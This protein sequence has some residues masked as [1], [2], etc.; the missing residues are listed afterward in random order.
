M[1]LSTKDIPVCLC[2]MI[3]VSIE[4]SFTFMRRHP[5]ISGVLILLIIVYLF[6]SYIYHFLVYLSPFLVCAA[7]FV[8]I[9]WSSEQDPLKYIKGD[10]KKA[11]QRKFDRQYTEIPSHVKRDLALQRRYSLRNATS[12]R[13]NFKDKKWN[14]QDIVVEETNKVLPTIT[15]NDSEDNNALSTITSNDSENNKE[16]STLP[17]NNDS[18]ENKEATSSDPEPPTSDLVKISD[19]DQQ[20]SRTDGSDGSALEK[21]NEN[22]REG[23]GGE[24]QEEGEVESLEEEE[25][26]EDSQEEANK[27][28]EWTNDDQKNLMDLGIS[29]IER[30]R[31]LESLIA[32]R[33]ARQHLKLQIEKGIIDLRTV[34]P[35]QIA[36][37][38]ITRINTTSD[39]RRGE[40]EGIDGIEIPGSAPS[41][42]RPSRNPFDLPYD[43]SEEK[44]NLTGDSFQQEFTVSHHQREMSYC[45]HESFNIGPSLPFDESYPFFINGRKISDRF[46][47]LPE[48]GNPDLII[49]KLFCK[50]SVGGSVGF[51]TRVKAPKPLLTKLQPNEET[52]TKSKLKF[53]LFDLII[54]RKQEDDD[55][56]DDDTA[57]QKQQQSESKPMSEAEDGPKIS[58]DEKAG[59]SEAPPPPLE[60]DNKPINEKFLNFPITTSSSNVVTSISESLPFES[61]SSS[62]NQENVLFSD[63]CI[64]HKPT[65]SIASDLQVEF[66]EVGS[67]TTL[68]IDGEES[69]VFDG[70]GGDIDKDII[71]IAT[72]GS[73]DFGEDL[74]AE[75]SNSSSKSIASLIPLQQIDE[76]EDT[77]AAT[78]LSGDIFCNES[79]PL[80]HQTQSEI[81]ELLN[82]K[83]S[84]SN[85]QGGQEAYCSSTVAADEDERKNNTLVILETVIYNKED[86]ENLKNGENS[87]DKTSAELEDQ[88]E[89]NNVHSNSGK[90]DA[91]SSN[92]TKKTKNQTPE[93]PKEV[94]MIRR[95]TRKNPLNKN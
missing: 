65:C 20:T 16:L 53:D 38:L 57:A 73:E 54:K 44:P 17:I 19:S 95:R 59:V 39:Y 71:A 89:V 22:S 81:P 35:S 34:S 32:R 40:Y 78:E 68:T 14:A 12:R 46:R 2:R 1:G 55:D 86:E 82:T 52:P 33:R 23:E 56:D 72:P 37:L 62:K 15:N 28:M 92:N 79:L 29:E 13:R 84:S 6:L 3:Q 51:S 5:L 69:V 77:S 70:D 90:N 83:S 31:R 64:F 42:L 18:D 91:Q 63:R 4:T 43:P 27:A 93:K 21:E 66:S 61:P 24:S 58:N 41:V 7:F 11:E 26:G 74:S 87:K 45:R 49:E 48:K 10:N 30:N 9:F 76:E 50:D 94:E 67:P 8:C 60:L 85:S 80:P 47:R 75:V 36:P 25:E 88:E